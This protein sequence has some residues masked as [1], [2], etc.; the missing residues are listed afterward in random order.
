MQRCDLTV[1]WLNN[2]TPELRT[3]RMVAGHIPQNK[4]ATS[5]LPRTTDLASPVSEALP[6]PQLLELLR[7][8]TASTV[9]GLE[10]NGMESKFK[11]RLDDSFWSCAVVSQVSSACLAGKV[12]SLAKFLLTTPHVIS[13]ICNCTPIM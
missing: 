9:F 5:E 1:L 4:A 6:Q 12:T 11:E 8:S 3:S 2:A 7:H 13:P 10:R